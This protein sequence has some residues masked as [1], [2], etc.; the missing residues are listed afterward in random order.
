MTDEA[1]GPPAAAAGLTEQEAARR[2][3]AR[4]EYPPPPSSRS[5]GS[6]VRSN[7][8]TLFNLI[9]A[10]FL[11]LILVSGQYLSLIHISEPTRPY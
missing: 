5:V 4:G 7:V 8:F 10:V 3:A 2:L 1:Q 6:I 9:L 11:V